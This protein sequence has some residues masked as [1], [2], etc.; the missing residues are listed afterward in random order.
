MSDS[1]CRG[2]Y[3]LGS[4]CGECRRCCNELRAKVE[5]Q[6]VEI[7]RY[8]LDLES[9]ATQIAA[10]KAGYKIGKLARNSPNS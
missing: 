9:M 7:N 10:A 4:A 5:K 3:G 8:K 2:S 6:A 1:I